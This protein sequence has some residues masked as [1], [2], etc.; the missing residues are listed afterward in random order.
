[1]SYGWVK[2]H[3]QTL[4]N[5][6]FKNDK[7]FRVFIYLLLSAR[8][9]EGEQMIGD[10]IVN[11]K[12]GQWATGRIAISR[13]TG[14]TQQNV[15]TALNKLEKL[16]I[17]TI[18]PT[19][20][21]SIISIVNWEKYQQDNQQVTNNQPASNQQVTTNKNGK[22]G[23]NEDK[24][25][26]GKQVLPPCPQ[27]ELLAIWSEAMPEQRQPRVWDGQRAANMTNRWKD[28]FKIMKSDNSGPLYDSKESGLI[29]WGSFF[30]YMR[31]SDFLMN[32][33]KPFG[34]DWIV[35]KANF[36]KIFEGNYHG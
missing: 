9:T 7:L 35:N 11:L 12:A 24:E 18:K 36:T 16:N 26:S 3:R 28:G 10:A 8:H 15:R 6:I 20:K 25:N 27:K 29:F 13:E 5:P 22:N 33:C 17:L 23:K 19:T 14:L 32:N 31:Q 1:M 30:D 34:L 4:S 2:L 21:F